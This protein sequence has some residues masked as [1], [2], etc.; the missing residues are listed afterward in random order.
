[1]FFFWI[2]FNLIFRIILCLPMKAGAS[3]SDMEVT[4]ED[5]Q[6]INKFNRLNNRFHELEDEI[7][8]AKVL[9]LW[10]NF[11]NIIFF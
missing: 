4:W 7:K 2:S 5:Q 8:T 3:G 10:F 1:M 6:N 9:F 11:S